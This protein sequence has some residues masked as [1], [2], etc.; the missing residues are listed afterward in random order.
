MNELTMGPLPAKVKVEF[1]DSTVAVPFFAV[2]CGVRD[3][4]ESFGIFELLDGAK[5]GRWRMDNG[6]VCIKGVWSK[7]RRPE[8]RS[9]YQREA[10][11]E[12]TEYEA[13][14]PE[15]RRGMNLRWG[16]ARFYREI[17][18]SENLKHVKQ[19]IFRPKDDVI[20]WPLIVK[21]ARCGRLSKIEGADQKA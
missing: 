2:R 14:T 4:P 20:E 11:A 5:P 18:Q 16:T 9:P 17:A 6:Y 19:H 12:F 1:S 13:A 7:T 8:T 10:I 21:C 3:C 15:A